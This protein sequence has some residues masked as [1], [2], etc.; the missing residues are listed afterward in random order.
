[1]QAAMVYVAMGLDLALDLY[2]WVLVARIV[3]SWT[4]TVPQAPV[5][6]RIFD[7]VA[8]LTDPVLDGARRLLPFLVVGQLDLS[9][10]AVFVGL[11]I[12]QQTLPGLVLQAAQL[13]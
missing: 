7:T 2:W 6:R 13:F 9:P 11:G 5:T 3:L 4:G 10:I 12:L 1:M 8:R